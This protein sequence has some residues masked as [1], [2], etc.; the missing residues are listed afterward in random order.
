MRNQSLLLMAASMLALGSV[1]ALAQSSGS[2]TDVGSAADI[3]VTAQKRSETLQEV[4]LAISRW[5]SVHWIRAR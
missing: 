1:P 2:I 4:P 3:I 5:P